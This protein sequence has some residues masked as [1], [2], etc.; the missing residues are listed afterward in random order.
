MFCIKCWSL[1]TPKHDR[2]N[3]AGVIDEHLGDAASVRSIRRT[4]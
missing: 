4:Q 3:P 2:E 1:Q